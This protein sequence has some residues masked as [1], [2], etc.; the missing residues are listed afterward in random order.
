MICPKCGEELLLDK[1]P[2]RRISDF[3]EYEMICSTCKCFIGLERINRCI[4]C[5]MG[6]YPVDVSKIFMESDLVLCKECSQID[7][8]VPTCQK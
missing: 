1:N 2:I 8:E 6:V 3:N 4:T 7:M 5:S